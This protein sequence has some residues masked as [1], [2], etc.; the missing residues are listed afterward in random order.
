[1][2]DK[3]LKVIRWGALG[4]LIVVG[5]T[6]IWNS[7]DRFVEGIFEGLRPELEKELSKPLGHP[8]V[9]G[10]YK[11]LRPWGIAIGPTELKAGLEDESTAKFS[12]LVIKYAPLASLFNW[13]PVAVI[14]PKG[15]YLNLRPN[16]SGALWVAGPTDE[17]TPNIALWLL[18]QDPARVFIQPSN[19]ELTAT[20]NT[21]FKLKEKMVTGSLQL[22]LPDNGKFFL[23]G[24]G[25][26]EKFALQVRARL[27][28]VKLKPFQSIFSAR[29]GFQ[30]QG[31]LNGDLQVKAEESGLK[32][33]GGITLVDFIMQGGS[34]ENP[35]SA[36]KATIRCNDSQALF[37]E[38]QWKYGPWVTSITGQIPLNT[39]TLHVGIDSSIRLKGV[40]SSEMNVKAM[41]PFSFTSE[42]LRTGE[43]LADFD[44][45]P[46]PLVPIGSLLETSLAGTLSAK[47]R[48]TGPLSA[49]KTNFDIGLTNPQVNGLRL[50]EVWSG[51]FQGLSGGGG[52]LTMSSSGAS[53]P[54]KLSANFNKNWKLDNLNV[55]RLGGEILLER[56]NNSFS[57][58]AKSFR[59]DRVEVAIPPEKSFKRIFGQLSGNGSV[60]ISPLS[61]D[62]EITMRYPRYMGLRLKEARLNGNYFENNFSVNGEILPPDQGQ[63]LLNAKGSVGGRLKAKAEALGVSARWI[64]D[65]VLQLPKINIKATSMGGNAKDLGGFFVK[66]FGDSLD[67]RLNALV[68]S[69]TSLLNSKSKISSTYKRIDPNDLQGEVDAVVEVAGADMENLNLD[70]KLSG[71]LWPTGRKSQIDFK[72]QPLV[73]TIRGPLQGGLGQFSLLNVPFSLLSLL[74]PVP[75]SLSGMFGISGQYRRSKGIPD[76]TAELVLEDARLAEKEFVLDRGEFSLT[77]SILKMD[78]LL[79]STS[80][81]EPLRLIGEVPLDPSSPIDFR[82]ESHGDGL[83]FLAGL[84]DG[85]LTWEKG[86]ADVRFL[87]RG[88]RDAPIANGFLVLKNGEFVVME[89]EIK[90]LN[91]SMVFDF[92]RLEILNLEGKMGSKGTV[93]GFGSIG[94]FRSEQE[95]LQPLAIK[96]KQVPLKLPY[97]EVEVA[98]NLRLKGALF[99]PQI[100]GNLTIKDGSFSP[101]KKS[102]SKKKISKENNVS[103]SFSR[104]RKMTLLPEQ[105]WDMK[106]PLNLFVQDSNSTASRIFRLSIPKKFS[107]ISFNKLR[108]RLGPKFQIATPPN[109]FTLQPLAIFDA[110]GLLTLN[111]ALDQTLAASG[112]VRLTKG[113]VNLFTTTFNFDRSKQNVAVFAPSMGLIPYVD[114]TMITSIPDTLRSAENLSSSSDFSTNGSGA[115]GIGGSRMIKVELIATGP[116][117][118]ISDNFQLTSRPTMPRNELIGL[119]GGNSLTSLFQGGESA[120]LGTVIGRSFISPLLGNVTD[121]FSE[122]LQFSLYPTTIVSSPKGAKDA[123]SSSGDETDTPQQAWVTDIGIDLNKKF[124]F[125]VQATPN[126]SDIPP[127]GTLR[128]AVNSNLDALG[129]LD[130]EG[131]WQSQFQLFLRY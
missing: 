86:T 26:W 98:S 114:V 12:G 61:I 7:T 38:S 112:V 50:Q 20:S 119:L 1:M 90:D 71:H 129:S 36:S 74:G 93:K 47:G 46:F 6:L 15:T 109:A 73:A 99:E 115:F 110:N 64:T 128:Y 18:L 19:L 87:I 32:C 45:K 14:S 118:R 79:R 121:S 39:G 49:L 42:G 88:T 22:G 3:S 96:M 44:L 103:A 106:K 105:R 78:V 29:S 104:R 52:E 63:V 101:P 24:S 41:L 72:V 40:D 94:L 4:T 125:S 37:P 58:K 48:I 111:G 102:G 13:R 100:G 80:S 82:V 30:A 69:Q 35:L 68:H 25:S 28:K 97:G 91:A 54:G 66:A 5:G 76:I 92:N 21:F 89:K 85:A 124:N 113:R 126:R 59:L 131:N 108:L 122:R 95:E 60:G 75:S 57:W 70:L 107:K 9:I 51:A 65:T 23:K 55:K 123:K 67:G 130:K 11:G 127:Q 17:P 77:D 56:F 117:D 31:Q 33:K 16:K 27:S 116:A 83:H 10:P 84:S 8:L 62:G 120:V 53:V 34:F 43:L 81:V 2:R